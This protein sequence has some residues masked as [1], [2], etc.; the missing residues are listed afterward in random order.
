MSK[1]TYGLVGYPLGHSFSRAY[2][3]DKFE[4]EDIDAQYLNFELSDIA[5]LPI[6]IAKY[7]G[8][9]GFN[10]T[11]PYKQDVFR[12]LNKLH[13]EAEKIGA[14]NVV[15]VETDGTLT[16]YNSDVYGFVE[17]MRPLLEGYNHKKALVL[18]VGGASRAVVHGLRT[19]GLEITRVSRREGAGDMTYSELSPRVLEAHTVIVNCTP[20]GM[21]PK[22]EDCPDIP[23]EAITSRHV[24]FDL[25]Y[26]PLETLFMKRC[27]RQGACVSNGLRMLH[28]QAERA[29]QIWQEDNL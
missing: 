2:F 11:I 15:K 12:Y 22:T 4:R 21:Y 10:V 17:S 25:V 18:G 27:A 3:T 16:G 1:E 28:L 19:L 23:Y 29:W 24:C 13:P 14:V 26:N 6:E 9:K 8:L 7:P 5:L 20:L